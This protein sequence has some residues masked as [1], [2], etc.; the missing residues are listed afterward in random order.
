MSAMLD[1][2]LGRRS[3]DFPA[4]HRDVPRHRFQVLVDAVMGEKPS[5]L[6]RVECEH[7]GLTAKLCSD[8]DPGSRLALGVR[9][10]ELPTIIVVR[11]PRRKQAVPALDQCRPVSLAGPLFAHVNTISSSSSSSLCSWRPFDGVRRDFPM[12]DPTHLIE[13]FSILPLRSF[14]P[15]ESRS[16]VPIRKSMATLNRWKEP[17]TLKAGQPLELR[18]GGG[19]VGRRSA[20]GAGG[21]IVQYVGGIERIARSRSY[22]PRGGEKP[23]TEAS[24]HSSEI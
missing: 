5:P 4:A 16:M 23:R 17:M 9:S 6:A 3:A 1:E 7:L 13:S 20:G 19:A 10:S 14:L 22:A 24:E 2:C 8:V 21:E 18:V 12:R 11:S 15:L